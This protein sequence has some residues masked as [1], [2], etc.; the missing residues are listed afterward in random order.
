MNVQRNPSVISE[1]EADQQ[2][3]DLLQPHILSIGSVVYIPAKY[4]GSNTSGLLPR[5]YNLLVKMDTTPDRSAGGVI[6]DVH[7]RKERMDE[8]SVTGVI[9]AVGATVGRGDP[10]PLKPGDRVYIDK[11]AGIKAIGMDGQ[12][13]RFIDEKQVGGS[14]TDEFKVLLEGGE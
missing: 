5:N 13:Y 6:I 10:E 2:K 11:Y 7:D 8:A 1:A 12:L 3:S 9:F 4:P 14:V